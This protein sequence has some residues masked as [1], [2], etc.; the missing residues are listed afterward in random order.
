MR[1][2]SY[3]LSASLL[4]LF[5]SLGVAQTSQKPIDID[6]QATHAQVNLIK[7]PSTSKVNAFCL[8]AENRILAACGAG[9]GEIRIMDSAGELIDSWEVSVKPEA[10]NTAP[11]GTILVAGKEKLLRFSADGKLLH[12]AVSPQAKALDKDKDALRA[13]AEQTVNRMTRSVSAQLESYTRMLAQ[14]EEK[15]EAGKLNSNE[16]NL[17]KVLPN[18]V[19]QL[20]ERKAQEE[21]QTPEESNEEAIVKQ[22]NLL[23]QSKLRVASISSDGQFVYIAT[24]SIKGYTFDVWR[25]DASFS[26]EEIVATELRGCCGQMDVQACDNGIYVAENA[27][28][29]VVRMKKDGEVVTSWGKR[30]RT[31]ADGFTS[32]CNPMN[33]CFGQNGDVYTAESNTGRIKRFAVDGTFKEFVGDVKLVPGCKNVSIA[34]SSDYD[35][36]YMLDI[37]RNHIVVMER[38]DVVAEVAEKENG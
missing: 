11:D 32:C 28:H 7:I 37:T 10:I 26:N 27:R 31:G 6:D 21:A 3:V 9:P 29:R 33:V 38:K 30:D 34:V 15:K 14:L 12:E 36:V 24:P 8:D 25:T 1:F 35:R 18:L 4:V 16:E 20:E 13:Q 17:L 19:K 2:S 5:T 22:M 23:A